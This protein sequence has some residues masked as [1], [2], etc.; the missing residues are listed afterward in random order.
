[1]RILVVSTYESGH[2]P[3][4][5]ATASTLLE[6]AGHDTVVLDLSVDPLDDVALQEVDA[7]AISVPMH[8]A[9]RLAVD[10]VDRI[11]KVRP[12][13]PIALFGLYAA[14]ETPL[15]G[16]TRIAGDYT[17]AL[18]EWAGHPVGSR[19]HQVRRSAVQVRVPRREALPALDR[20]AR[21]RTGDEMLPVGYVQASHG[22][23]HR[24]RHCPVP[25]VYDGRIS[26]VDDAAVLADID[27]QVAAGARHITFGDPDFLNAPAHARRVITRFASRHPDV[28]FDI[29]VKV[30]HIL[31]HPDVWA[32]FA[33]AGCLF[34]VSAFETLNDDILER[35]DK[36]HTRAD[37]AK[38]IHLLREHGI[39]IRPS[40]L[41]FT[42]WT[43]IDDVVD[44][45][46]FIVDHDLV[47]NTDPVQLAI[48][49]LVPGGSL[50]LEGEEGRWFGEYDPEALTYRWSGAP[51]VEALQTE[52]LA[53]AERQAE[54]GPA[55]GFAAMW[56]AVAQVAGIPAEELAIPHGATAGVPR[57]TE[58]WFC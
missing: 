7:V 21:L 2:Q 50:L 45:F 58:P 15:D 35:L 17:Q 47:E 46:R 16:L 57:M 38:A 8:T 48:R 19:T 40:W 42:P 31:A 20:Y 36:G 4:H 22:C 33:A 53:I 24:C 27:Q 26:I 39:E 55:A 37:A 34:V 51:E 14:V 10:T 29:T 5:A 56:D 3:L 18:M 13:L 54:A 49:L 41:P 44:I 9:L 30:E 28:T 52:L 11:Q 1:M 43:T 6:D 25:V 12:G 32:E 23:R